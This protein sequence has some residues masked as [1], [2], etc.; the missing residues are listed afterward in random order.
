MKVLNALDLKAGKKADYS[1]LGSITQ[2]IQFL[3]K[4]EKDEEWA[5]WNMDWLEWQ[6]IKQVRRN[7]K[8]LLKNYKL[9]KGIID[10]T[11]YI[12]E[13]DNDMR[14]L[15][16]TLTAEDA[17]A[18]E[19][20]FYPIIPNVINILVSEFAK[21]NSKITF[22]GVDDKSY[23]EM[24]DQKRAMIEQSL[25]ANAEAKMISNMMAQGM[26]PESPEFS[27]SLDPEKL[28]T[29]PEIQEFFSKSYTSLCEEWAGHQT[30]ADE[31]RFRMDNYKS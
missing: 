29:L 23:N 8:R 25:L 22:M 26:D 6:G 24:L 10:K 28:K 2:P 27:Q 13:E 16:E 19:L 5:A 1:R 7:A 11:D 4:H 18:L 15:M 3:S 17:G 9:A 20:K 21:R 31:E 14:D 30:R 12:V